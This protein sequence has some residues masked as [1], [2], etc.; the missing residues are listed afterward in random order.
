MTVLCYATS[1]TLTR[2]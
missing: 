2:V 1:F